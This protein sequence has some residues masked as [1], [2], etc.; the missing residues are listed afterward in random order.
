MLTAKFVTNGPG[1]YRRGTLRDR[2]RAIDRRSGARQLDHGAIAG[3]EL[4]A[5][6]KT[7]A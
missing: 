6:P 2:R 4:P 5:P 7:R 3:F 1:P